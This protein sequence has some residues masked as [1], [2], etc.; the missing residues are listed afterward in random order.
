MNGPFTEINLLLFFYPEWTRGFHRVPP[1]CLCCLP[2][3]ICW[4][5]QERERLS[6]G[7]LCNLFHFTCCA[8][9]GWLFK[10]LCTLPK[11]G[12][13]TRAVYRPLAWRETCTLLCTKNSFRPIICLLW[14]LWG[15]FLTPVRALFEHVTS[16]ARGLLRELRHKGTIFG[17]SRGC[18]MPS[19]LQMQH[20]P[21]IVA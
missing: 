10:S 13:I 17:L 11:V 8:T 12:K 7:W 16:H 5:R 18:W 21:T 6:G 2:N 3:E 4:W 20:N 19:C 9:T 1:L 14:P 15:R